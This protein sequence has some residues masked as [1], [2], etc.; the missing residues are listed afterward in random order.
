MLML[1]RTVGQSIVIGKDREISVYLMSS[2]EGRVTIGVD[3]DISIPVFRNEL[4]TKE[5][6][7]EFLRKSA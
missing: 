6:N 7:D 3:A 4:L 5:N 2:S 1:N